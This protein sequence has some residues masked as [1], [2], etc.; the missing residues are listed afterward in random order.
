[1]GVLVQ[2]EECRVMGRWNRWGRGDGKKQGLKGTG[3]DIVGRR[4]CVGGPGEIGGRKGQKGCRVAKIGQLNVDAI[5]L[6][7]GQTE[8]ELLFIL[9]TFSLSFSMGRD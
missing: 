5:G 3:E 8:Y 4:C 7:T 9:F 1:M 6:Q 2:W